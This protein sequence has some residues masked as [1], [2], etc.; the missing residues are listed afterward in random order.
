[1]RILR[2][3]NGFS[4]VE[5]LITVGLIGILAGVATV[6]LIRELPNYR[7]KDAT[8][9]LFS[10][11]QAARVYAIRN[12]MPCTLQ[13]FPAGTDNYRLVQNGAVLKTVSLSAFSGVSF[14]SL[15]STAPA[16]DSGTFASDSLTIQP[17]GLANTGRFYLKSSRTPPDGRLVDVTSIGRPKI[18]IWNGT[19]YN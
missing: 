19:T 14:G 10:D 7:L 18:M 11:I 9:A 6:T 12:G 2:N 16:P 4:L 1:M 8:R 17:S 15:D 13:Q 3:E 5:M